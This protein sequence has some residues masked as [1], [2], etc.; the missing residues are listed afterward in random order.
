MTLS[1]IQLT[2]LEMIQLHVKTIVNAVKRMDIDDALGSQAIVFEG[3]SIADFANMTLCEAQADA[4]AKFEN[5]IFQAPN[6]STSAPKVV[7]NI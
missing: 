2:I 1:M 6:E 7:D 5:D 4:S 3:A